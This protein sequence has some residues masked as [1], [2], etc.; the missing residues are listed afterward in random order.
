[1]LFGG[2]IFQNK[3]PASTIAYTYG[4]TTVYAQPHKAGAQVS[5]AGAQPQHS[6]HPRVSRDRVRAI[7]ISHRLSK[8]L[9]A[10]APPAPHHP[11]NSCLFRAHEFYHTARYAL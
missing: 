9:P 11:P 8:N 7:K 10:P 4:F 6:T 1:M 5:I 3:A 2:G